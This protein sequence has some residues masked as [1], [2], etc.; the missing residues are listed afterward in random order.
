MNFNN[1]SKYWLHPLSLII[2]WLSKEGYNSSEKCNPCL[3]N[4]KGFEDKF[5]FVSY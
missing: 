2:L 5:N 3:N 1:H 4:L